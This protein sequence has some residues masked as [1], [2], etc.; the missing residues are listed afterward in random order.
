MFDFLKR[1]EESW[2]NYTHAA[3]NM[4]NVEKWC[5]DNKVNLEDGYLKCLARIKEIVEVQVEQKIPVLSF[6]I[7][8]LN[9]E[10]KTELLKCLKELLE[11]EFKTY[12]KENGI[13]ITL[14]GKWYDLPPEV[15]ESL[16]RI[17]EETKDN[18]SL[19]LNLCLN[20]GGQEE[21][22]DAFKIMARQLIAGKLST[23]NISKETIKENIYS[24]YFP[25]P[26]LMIKNGDNVMGSFFLWDCVNAKV[27]F[28]EKDFPDFSKSD[29]EK[30]LK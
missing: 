26:D 25:P 23:E 11:G 18:T 12:L 7:L 17:V 29:F 24:S 27:I 14:L 16:K 9:K 19:F 8:P 22:V 13:R 15:L 21:L 2:V 1:K 20:Y 10:K 4:D 28:T 6:L 30:A 3:V 5:E